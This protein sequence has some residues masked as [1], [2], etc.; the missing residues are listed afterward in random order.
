M[1]AGQVVSMKISVI[2]ISA[3]GNEVSYRLSYSRPVK[4]YFFSDNYSVWY[5]K[6]IETASIPQS[7][8]AIPL[9]SVIAPVAWAI[10]ADIEMEAL[11]ETYL[12]SL[13]DVRKVLTK[14]YS[15]FSTFGTL[16][17][18]NVV[19]NEFSGTRTGLLFSRGL[20][21]FTS[22]VKHKD[23][24]PD[25]ISVWSEDP[26]LHEEEK[27]ACVMAAARWLGERDG[28]A[29]LKIKTDLS[30]I[31]KL[32]LGSEFGFGNW[33]AQVAHGLQ[34]LG[35]CAPITAARDIGRVLI[36]SS[37]PQDQLIPWG[38]H[39]AIDNN[40]SWA[41][42]TVTHD[43]VEM[44]R[45]QKIRYVCAKDRECLT[46]L[47]VCHI[48]PMNCGKCEKCLRTI[49]GLCMEGINPTDCGFEV[50]EKTLDNA[51]ALFVAGK[52]PEQ[53]ELVGFWIEMQRL[54]PEEPGP[55]LIGW[56]EFS[57]WLR[58]YDFSR[59]RRRTRRHFTRR[60][61]LHLLRLSH[62]ITPKHMTRQ[63]LEYVRYFAICSL[64]VALYRGRHLLVAALRF[65]RPSY[66]KPRP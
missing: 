14:W 62:S 9:V 57:A 29:S 27:W 1:A 44:S 65:R 12:R 43:A 56:R 49:V 2:D 31:N 36:A 5:D 3:N 13:N 58:G 46:R 64:H 6:Q 38:S 59:Q 66:P 18:R 28:V 42:V 39:P 40:V 25:L 50:D 11:D 4:K 7:I 45:Q 17:V 33:Y 35:M 8:L 41:R 54:L 24:K 61:W 52:M 34:L 48:S 22:Y 55:D 20:D 53:D 37:F 32:L 10:G 21:S 16:N 26:L 19:R 60:A 23:E 63:H 51:K 15:R 47:K 30:Y